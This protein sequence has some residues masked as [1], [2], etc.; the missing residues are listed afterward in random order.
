MTRS[1]KILDVIDA[2]LQTPRPDPSFGEVSETVYDVC[3]RC[4]RAPFEESEFCEGCRAF[5]L[6]DGDDPLA[7]RR[8]YEA[9]RRSARI[10]DVVPTDPRGNV[11]VDWEAHGLPT[12]EEVDEAFALVA[13]VAW[14]MAAGLAEMVPV[15]ARFL[16]ELVEGLSAWWD[17]RFE[18]HY[19][20]W[21]MP[22]VVLKEG[23][24]NILCGDVRG[25][26]LDQGACPVGPVTLEVVE[27]GT[28]PHWDGVM[29][30]LT[31][32]ERKPDLAEASRFA[33]LDAELHREMMGRR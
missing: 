6:G 3:V 17:A 5:L 23:G 15:L 7:P 26:L 30:K 28:S 9:A 16:D 29:L 2:G 32:A 4:G 22:R 27:H 25:R 21:Y 20:T 12:D 31:W 33:E 18:W 14:A 8:A 13:E 10:G 1:Q 24:W 11:R 19:V